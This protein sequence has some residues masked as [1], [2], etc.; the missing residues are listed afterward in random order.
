MAE[1]IETAEQWSTLQ[2]LGCEFGQGYLFA[3]PGAPDAI[4]SI[5]GD[6]RI[7]ERTN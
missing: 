1:G 5:L 7:P 2:D 4:S 6:A 3:R